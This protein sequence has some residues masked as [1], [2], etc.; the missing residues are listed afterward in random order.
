M[1]PSGDTVSKGDAL[2]KLTDESM[3]AAKSYYEDAISDAE[4]TLKQ[5]RRIL[6]AENFLRRAQSRTPI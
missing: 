5:P 2:F 4:N 1:L 3:E 6:Q